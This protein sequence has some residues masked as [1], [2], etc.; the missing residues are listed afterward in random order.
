MVSF[1]NFTSFKKIKNSKLKAIL[2]KNI[3]REEYKIIRSSL[4]IINFESKILLKFLTI[5]S[6]K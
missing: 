2:I 4:C 1:A 3:K 6:I 5:V